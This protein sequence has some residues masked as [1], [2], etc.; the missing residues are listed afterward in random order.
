MAATKSYTFGYWDNAGE[1]NE[2]ACIER[3]W[4]GR[5]L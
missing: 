4:T 1:W 5:S 2:V 3:T